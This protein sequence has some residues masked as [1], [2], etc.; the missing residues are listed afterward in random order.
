MCIERTQE[1][2]GAWRSPV[3]MNHVR[4]RWPIAVCAALALCGAGVC[5]LGRK[6][7]SEPLRLDFETPPSRGARQR[8]GGRGHRAAARS[9]IQGGGANGGGGG[10]V[11]QAE[12]SPP[13]FMEREDGPSSPFPPISQYL[14]EPASVVWA[15]QFGC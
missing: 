9:S 7:H 2:A 11:V 3:A 6:M 10:G 12:D 5:L 1:R 4:D 14:L 15:L 13:G 8:T